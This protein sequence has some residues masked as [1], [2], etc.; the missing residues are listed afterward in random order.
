MP[1]GLKNTGA[2]YKR[3]VKKMF[4][5]HIGKSMEVYMGDM[6][7]KNRKNEGHISDLSTTFEVLQHY[8]IKLNAAKYSFR[9]SPSEFLGFLVNYRRFEA[10]PEKIEALRNIRAPTTVKEMQKLIRM[11][12][13]LNRVISKCS[14][15]CHPF[16]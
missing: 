13:S 1:F 7:V 6:L 3:L 8:I 12:V 15:K 2:T 4:R 9:V 10:N 14:N 5:D 16:F 11:I